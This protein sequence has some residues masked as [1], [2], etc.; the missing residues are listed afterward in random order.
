MAPSRIMVDSNDY[1]TLMA[2][3]KSILQ[4]DNLLVEN[5]LDGLSVTHH[6]VHR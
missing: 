2:F 6:R 3:G 4:T 1:D 5:H